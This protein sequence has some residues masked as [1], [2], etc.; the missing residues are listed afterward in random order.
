M[1]VL[2][3][4]EDTSS[5]PVPK[6]KDVREESQLQVLN[7]EVRKIPA[8]QRKEKWPLQISNELPL[9]SWKEEETEELRDLCV[10]AGDRHILDNRLEVLDQDSEEMLLLVLAGNAENIKEEDDC[11]VEFMNQTSLSWRTVK[12]E[13]PHRVQ[14]SSKLAQQT[15]FISGYNTSGEWTKLSSSFVPH[16]FL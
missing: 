16:F 1:A 11:C 9:V 13:E 2:A 4:K 12:E 7:D 8:P 5:S 15:K 10:E 3:D 6:G 14:V